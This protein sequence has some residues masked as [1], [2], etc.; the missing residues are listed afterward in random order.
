MPDA[1]TLETINRYAL[2][3]AAFIMAGVVLA[4]WTAYRAEVRENKAA[5]KR[6]SDDLVAEREDDHLKRIEALEKAVAAV[7]HQ[8]EETTGRY[9]RELES[10]RAEVAQIAKDGAVASEKLASGID[11]LVAFVERAQAGKGGG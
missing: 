1:T 2:P 7:R 6:R 5:L 4:L 10:S 11:R 9:V 3:L 8:H